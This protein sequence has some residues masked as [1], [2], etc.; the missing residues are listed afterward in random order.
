MKLNIAVLGGGSWGT[1]IVKM[2]CENVNCVN[3][4]IRNEENVLSLT[5]SGRNSNYLRSINLNVNKISQVHQLLMLSKT[6]MF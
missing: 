6:L 2:L 4:Y 3:W 1:A 5:K